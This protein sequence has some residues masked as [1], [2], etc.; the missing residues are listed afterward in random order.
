[1]KLANDARLDDVLYVWFAQ[2]RSPGI[3]GRIIMAKALELNDKLN[4]GDEKFKESSDWLQKFKS[5]HMYAQSDPK[6]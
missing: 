4:P 5:R 1:M 3:P 6:R 2:K